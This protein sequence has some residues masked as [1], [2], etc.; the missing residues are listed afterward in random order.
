MR[1][2]AFLFTI[3]SLTLHAQSY[4][5]AA[6]Q[7]GSTAIPADSP[8]FVAWATGV[9]VTRGLIDISNP[10]LQHNGSNYATYGQPEDA[11]GPPTN[12]VVSLGD[13]GVA[14]LTFDKPI[15]DGPGFDFAV[16]ENGFDDNFLEL[17]FVEVSS[18]GVDYFKFPSHSQTQTN[19]Q[20]GGF[21]PLDPTY[22]NNLAGKYRAFYGTPFNL[23]ELE[24][25]PNLDKNR[26]THIKIIDVVGSIDPL[27][28]RYDS[29]GNVI[30]DP[31]TTPFYSS[32]F[33]LDG[34]G[35]INELV[36]GIDT[37]EA[38][39]V[40]IYPN[41]TTKYLYINTKQVVQ[42]TIYDMKGRII[43]S[44]K[45]NGQQGLNVSTL[46]NGIYVLRVGFEG[47]TKLFRFI[48]E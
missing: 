37:D 32:G 5:P 48:K 26:V 40:S 43:L 39:S 31:F 19:V 10:E 18:N 35:V 28:A 27:Y 8:L 2:L 29:F 24:D 11:L 20:V 22:L 21:D 33:D 23:S 38:I 42:A 17:A 12:Q 44:E 9:S 14:I 36:L 41:P 16:F 25:N 45:N 1:K 34:V 13:A 46:Q 15:T 4:P 7:M 6:G 3:L 30:N 47:K